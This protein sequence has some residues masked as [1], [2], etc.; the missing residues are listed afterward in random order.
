STRSVLRVDDS[1]PAGY[2]T[3]WAKFGRVTMAQG[4]TDLDTFVG[5]RAPFDPADPT[6]N[7]V[8]KGSGSSIRSGWFKWYYASGAGNMEEYW[9]IT[10]GARTWDIF[11]DGRTFYLCVQPGLSATAALVP[12]HAGDFDSLQSPDAFASLLTATE[13]A[14][15]PQ[16]RTGVNTSGSLASTYTDTG[17]MMLRS[18]LGEGGPVR[19]MQRTI[20]VAK[21]DYFQ[22][23]Y[24][25]NV[26]FPNGPGNGLLLHPTWLQQHDGH[27]RGKLRGMFSVLNKQTLGHRAVVE[28]VTGLP[29]MRAALVSVPVD[30]DGDRGSIAFDITGPW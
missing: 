4:M 24:M 1:C 15:D 27:M 2:D 23:G 30:R 17:R 20:S 22:S 28:G 9:S 26:P 19:C 29:G 10:G 5:A 16:T 18:Y 13:H 21:A 8:P 25:S 6:K 7:E 11:G 3:N 14:S 12:Y